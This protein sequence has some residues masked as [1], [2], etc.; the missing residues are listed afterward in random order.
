MASKKLTKPKTPTKPNLLGSK[1][2]FFVLKE[3]SSGEIKIFNKEE[4]V[5]EGERLPG[6]STPESKIQKTYVNLVELVT[7]T[8]AENDVYEL[9]SS[10]RAKCPIYLEELKIDYVRVPN[11]RKPYDSHVR[12]VSGFQPLPA[13]EVDRLN[14][15]YSDA[16]DKYKE[17][18]IDY[19]QKK[20]QQ[21]I[22][23]LEKDLE[24]L[25]GN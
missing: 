14:K 11:L 8:L 2:Y 13:G 17:E 12:C 18:F 23:K 7:Q 21:E 6:G 5:A 4:L 3:N 9:F 24:K 15:E 10:F 1:L 19:Q 16:L 20:K 22:E 25:K